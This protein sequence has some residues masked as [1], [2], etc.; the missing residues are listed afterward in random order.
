MRRPAWRRPTAEASP[1]VD[2]AAVLLGTRL[3]S[4]GQSQSGRYFLAVHFLALSAI[5]TPPEAD[6]HDRDRDRLG[7][8][9]HVARLHRRG[10][11]VDPG[12]GG[13]RPAPR[14]R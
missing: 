1:A 4:S 14:R 10:P 12:R 8:R 7:H 6:R 2:E 9:E 13:G 11:R 3:W 5:L